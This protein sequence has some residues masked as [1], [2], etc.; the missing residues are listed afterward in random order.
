M[1]QQS[2]WLRFVKR[3]RSEL[4]DAYPCAAP[5]RRRI[6]PKHRIHVPQQTATTRWSKRGKRIRVR[7]P[8]SRGICKPC[9]D[10]LYER[11]AAEYPTH[12]NRRTRMTVGV[13]R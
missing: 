3:R 10:E 5:T 6:C 7:T 1:S 9:R 13:T 11:L 4:H 12:K 2:K 8:A